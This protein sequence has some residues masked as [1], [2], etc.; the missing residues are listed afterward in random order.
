[1]LS[2]FLAEHGF[3]DGKEHHIN[4]RLVAKD[5]ELIIRMRDDCKP[6]NLKDYYLMIHESQDKQDEKINMAIIFKM[7]KDIQYTATFGANNIII[8]I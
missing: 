1:M 2:V 5:G 4:M 7:A 3:K 8:K 6:L